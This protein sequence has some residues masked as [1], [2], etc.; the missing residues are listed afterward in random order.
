MGRKSVF[1]LLLVL[2]FLLLVSCS[3]NE[4]SEQT[5]ASETHA[6]ETTPDT[7]P[8]SSD[9]GTSV[10]IGYIENINFSKNGITIPSV[11]FVSG[12]LLVI[13]EEQRYRYDVASLLALDN[14][15][16]S[17]VSLKAQNL[18]RLYGKKSQNYVLSSA[19]IFLKEDAFQPLENMMAAFVADTGKKTVQV[20]SGYSY[21]G[22]ESLSSSFVTG[23]S[24]AINLIEDGANYSLASSEKTIT[25]NG[26]IM[27]CLDWFQDHCAKYGFIYTGL[28]GSQART[29]ATF[30]YV[31]V[32]HALAMQRLDFVDTKEY[33]NFLRYYS[34]VHTVTDFESGITWNI[35]FYAAEVGKAVTTISI[36]KNA[37]YTVS[38]NNVDGFIV[39]YYLPKS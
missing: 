24:I 36:P 1:I 12:T 39:A 29:L 6:A 30:R 20:V 25:V 13:D 28:E 5:T 37:V 26:K 31:G 11:S 34:S 17:V 10:N 8:E 9:Q 35:D 27:T 22:E 32:P 33:A 21:N 18:V 15:S 4:V 3:D 16:S 7:E 14:I 2:I 38:G 23:Y 19:R